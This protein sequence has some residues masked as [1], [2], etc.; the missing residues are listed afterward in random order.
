MSTKYFNS[1]IVQPDAVSARAAVSAVQ[2]TYKRD[3][4]F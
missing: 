2:P 4:L 3:Q 1:I